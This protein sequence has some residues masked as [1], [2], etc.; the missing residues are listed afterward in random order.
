MTDLNRQAPTPRRVTI[1]DVAR[2]SNTS[3]STV[4]VA[5]AGRPGVSDETRARVLGVA[6]RLGWRPDRRAS[7]LRRQDVRLVGVVYEAESVFQARL[8][9]ALYVAAEESNVQLVLAAATA[10][11]DERKCV[12]V[13][14]QERCQSL[15]LTGSGLSS[16]EIRTI[17]R[18]LPT[19][20]LCRYVHEE[21]VDAVVTDD[22]MG[23]GLLIDHL[24][25][26]G[27]RNI[28][29]ADG[30]PGNLLSGRRT[31]AYEKA[32]R[33]HGL[34]RWIRVISGGTT[35]AEGVRV[36]QAV[37]ALDPAP[38]AV[39][40]YNDALSAA[41][42]R[43]LRGEGVGVPRDISVTGYDDGPD[44]AD[45]STGLTTVQQEP[46]DLARV[47][48]ELMSRRIDS[49]AVIRSGDE[50]LVVLP[51]SLVIRESTGP[52]RPKT[53]LTSEVA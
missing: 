24:V 21:G 47:A 23:Y 34:E 30:G 16:A 40:C 20:S 39:T 35:I 2:A 25:E 31:V 5:L 53:R 38:T 46:T 15:I 43:T 50:E 36:A 42:V 12:N 22:D 8:L 6:N 18:R 9:D 48:M 44:S 13:L 3:I 10:H 51:T 11:H 4:S 29:H 37:M 1:R 52:V 17:G 28:V 14:L 19:L 45:P 26:L 32:M 33:A 27:H 41:L 7:N 49:G